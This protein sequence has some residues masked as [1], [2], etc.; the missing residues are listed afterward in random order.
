MIQRMPSHDGFGRHDA[1]AMPLVRAMG[2]TAPQASGTVQREIQA[3][4]LAAQILGRDVATPAPTRATSPTADNLTL[5]RMPLAVVSPVIQRAPETVTYISPMASSSGVL[6]RDGAEP[7]TTISPI[8]KKKDEKKEDKKEETKDSA[9]AM[10]DLDTLAR[11][12]LPLLKRMLIVER[13]RHVRR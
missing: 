10:P 5:R 9:A 7:G 6:Q 11:Q 1:T 13:E 3:D 8:A 12:V 2:R 4:E